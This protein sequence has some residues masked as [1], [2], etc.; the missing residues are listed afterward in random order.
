MRPAELRIIVVFA[1]VLGSFLAAGFSHELGE[2][3]RTVDRTAIETQALTQQACELRKQLDA[4][5]TTARARGFVLP[6][7]G[8]DALPAAETR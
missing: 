2:L 1:I 7:H 5:E 6:P 8:P 3:R 4:L